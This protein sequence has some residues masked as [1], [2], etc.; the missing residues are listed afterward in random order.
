MLRRR[1]AADGCAWRLGSLLATG[2]PGITQACR[3]SAWPSERLS[4]SRG[5]GSP[6]ATV[7]EVLQMRRGGVQHFVAV[8]SA[9]GGSL[10]P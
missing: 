6:R 10:R 4:G 5:A 3:R 8:A 7:G 9:L 1:R 2:A